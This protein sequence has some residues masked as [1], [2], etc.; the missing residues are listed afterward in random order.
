VT[1]KADPFGEVKG[2]P[3]GSISGSVAGTIVHGLF[4]N[5]AALAALA[6]RFGLQANEVIDPYDRL[7]DHFA[8]SLR[9]DL[10]D[11]L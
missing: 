1:G 5:P 6:E 9:M 3:E 10:I 8:A 7:A 2:E 4:E 11:A